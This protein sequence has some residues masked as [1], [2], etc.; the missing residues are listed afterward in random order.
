MRLALCQIDTTVG[1]LDGNAERTRQAAERAAAAGA[2]LAVLP[3]LTLTG[4]PPR[5]LLDRAPFDARSI[6]WPRRCRAS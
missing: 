3:E 5:D 1:D 4:Y 6:A 2:A